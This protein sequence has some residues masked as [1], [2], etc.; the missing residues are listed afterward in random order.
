MSAGN[1]VYSYQNYVDVVQQQ[2]QNQVYL[3]PQMFT[4][5]QAAQLQQAQQQT[6]QSAQAQQAPLQATDIQNLTGTQHNMMQQT[7]VPQG[8]AVQQMMPPGMIIS[9]GMGGFIQ[10]PQTISPFGAMQFSQ[11]GA[12]QLAQMGQMQ[13]ILQPAMNIRHVS[14]KI[15]CTYLWCLTQDFMKPKKTIYPE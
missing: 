11:A 2:Q 7:V 5:Q 8:L 12:H 9:N 4:V 3:D 15:L 6:T 13:M 14:I 10:Y 1:S